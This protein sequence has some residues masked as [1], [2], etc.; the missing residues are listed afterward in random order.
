MGPAHLTK[1][2]VA[3]TGRPGTALGKT[4]Q[5]ELTMQHATSSAYN[6]WIPQYAMEGQGS[7]QCSQARPHPNGVCKPMSQ[8]ILVTTT[9]SDMQKYI[10]HHTQE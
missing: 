3:R 9:Y 10:M 5:I 6:A 2:K 4:Q 8:C 1:A 7:K